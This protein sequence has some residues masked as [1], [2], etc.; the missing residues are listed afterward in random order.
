MINSLWCCSSYFPMSTGILQSHYSM[1]ETLTT[2]M[3]WTKARPNLTSTFCVMF[4]TGRISL[5]Y[6]RNRS[7][8][9]RSSSSEHRPAKKKK[10]IIFL[11]SKRIE[12][13]GVSG[14]DTQ[15]HVWTYEKE[16]MGEV[17]HNLYLSSRNIPVVIIMDDEIENEDNEMRIQNI[18]G[19]RKEKR[20]L[21]RRN[22]YGE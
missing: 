11:Y 12:T 17:F 19:K 7:L 20:L 4:C 6:P 14:Q 9:R 18:I 1:V 21:A 8:T 13:N 22:K 5:L 2:F 3:S 10:K 16:V 15:T